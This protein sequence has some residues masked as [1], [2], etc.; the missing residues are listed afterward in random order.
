MNT[1]KK[2]KILMLAPTPYFADRGCHVR[3][4]EEAKALRILG[5][6]VRICTYHLG[7]DL[8]D[9]PTRRIP[10]IPWYRKLS[11]GPSWHKFYLDLLLFFTAFKAIREL[12]PDL[13]HAHLH[14]GALVGFLLKML[15]GIPMV[16]DCQGSLTGELVEH[17]F[18]RRGSWLYRVFRFLEGW[19]VRRADRTVCSAGPSA[20]ILIEDFAI[21]AEIVSVV[22]DGVDVEIFRPGLE[23]SGLRRELNLPQDRLIAVFMGVMSEHQGVDMLLE[24]IGALRADGHE[25]YC[26]LMGY[27]EEGYR[28]R[29]EEL[30][31]DER[32]TFTGRIE[33]SRA[34]EYLNLGDLAL[35]PKMSDSEANG[36]ILNYMACGLPVI[37][38][39]NPVNREILGE[40]GV[41]VPPGDVGA[42]AEAVEKLGRDESQRRRLAGA[43]R[44]RAVS[45]HGW[46]V[47]ARS[48]VHLYNEI[49]VARRPLSAD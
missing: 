36:K 20:R 21:P 23:V 47:A 29:A 9:I 41:L 44:A 48:L 24:A 31:L 10:R 7:R 25:V 35:A 15:F 30:G 1:T 3:I 2:L 34:A 49:F 26:L 45:E 4:Y 6:D 40:T 16:F 13:I 32:V 28:R 5:H 38:F 46:D 37:A 12:S 43:A 8:G 17:R 11:A 39:D 27:P 33:Y 18:I 42:F 22:A 14:E 19:I